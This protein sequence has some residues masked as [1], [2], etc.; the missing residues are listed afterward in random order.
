VTGI[1][2]WGGAVPDS[3]PQFDL[4]H[5]L[6]SARIITQRREL[7]DIL[8]DLLNGAELTQAEGNWLQVLQAEETGQP[9]SLRTLLLLEWLR[10]INSNLNTGT[11]FQTHWIWIAK[12]V[13]SVLEAL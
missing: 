8:C 4:L 3:L 11:L 12:N 5:L 9:L 1:V 13:K 10:H 2:D 6:L 7:G